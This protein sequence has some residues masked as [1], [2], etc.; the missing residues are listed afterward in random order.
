M[1][2]FLAV[3]ALANLWGRPV[4]LPA[5]V[6]M[7][8]LALYAFARVFF[9]QIRGFKLDNEHAG[10]FFVSRNDARSAESW[11]KG[12]EVFENLVVV[13]QIHPEPLEH[14]FACIVGLILVAQ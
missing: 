5:V 9:G 7:K 8:L 3:I 2:P 12:L 4:R 6:T 13:P 10:W 11:A 14:S 1:P